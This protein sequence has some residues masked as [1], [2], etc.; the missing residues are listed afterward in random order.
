MMLVAADPVEAER[1]GVLEL[2]QILVVDVVALLGIVERV[3]DVDPH[4]TVLGAEI[5]RQIGPRHQVEPREFHRS[6]RES[7]PGARRW[8]RRPPP[9]RELSI[10][11]NRVERQPRPGYAS[12]LALLDRCYQMS[13]SR[14]YGRIKRVRCPPEPGIPWGRLRRANNRGPI[15]GSTFG[16]VWRRQP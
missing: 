11:A 4:G 15:Q 9:S 7:G 13:Y 14:I 10:V 2:V 16:R 8:T 3:R 1:L 5:V 12:G 6:L